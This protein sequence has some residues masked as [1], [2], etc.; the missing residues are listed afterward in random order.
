MIERAS[1]RNRSGA[2]RKARPAK[3]KGTPPS[4][5]KLD[6]LSNRGNRKSETATIHINESTVQ[7]TKKKYS[8]YP[9]FMY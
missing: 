7:G 6:G 2:L 1:R 4:G 3:K 9:D 5:K 8:W